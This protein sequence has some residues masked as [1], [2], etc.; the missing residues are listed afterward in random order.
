MTFLTSFVLAR[1]SL[2][3]YVIDAKSDL[4]AIVAAG[5]GTKTDLGGGVYRY[6]LG[7]KSFGVRGLIDLGSDCLGFVSGATQNAA[8]VGLDP[9][10]S[11]FK[12]NYAGPL[13]RV[14][15]AL[16]TDPATYGR[17]YLGGLRFTNDNASG[18]AL[19]TGDSGVNVVQ[20]VTAVACTFRQGAAAQSK[21]VRCHGG[22]VSFVTCDFSKT[23]ATLALGAF[24]DCADVADAYGMVS[25]TGCSFHGRSPTLDSTISTTDA[26]LST[27]GTNIV[28]P[29]THYS[30]N[31]CFF[32][33]AG[34]FALGFNNNLPAVTLDGC[35]IGRMTYL[36][37]LRTSPARTMPR[38]I[39]RNLIAN[40]LN[41]GATLFG[42]GRPKIVDMDRCWNLS[43]PA[44]YDGVYGTDD[45]PSLSPSGSNNDY[46][47]TVFRGSTFPRFNCAAPT[48]ITGFVSD[49]GGPTEKTIFNIGAGTLTLSNESLSSTAA[50]RMTTVTGADIVLP[51]SYGI[52][53]LHYD[54]V[55]ERWRVWT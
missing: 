14:A 21:V 23:D 29:V 33:H 31:G 9:G 6:E 30:F 16:D 22:H 11:G 2:T 44:V 43:L 7:P 46:G 47:D 24:V 54:Y 38:L 18:Y 40:V 36:T 20:R 41:G 19:L 50:N 39:V 17:I 8:L 42:G 12:T 3:D 32:T 15:G 37:Y 5:D 53:Y 34:Q 13:L 55:A 51:A 35:T 49:G 52:A 27:L 48:T 26:I 4:D 10:S 28:T 1:P 25:F 45:I